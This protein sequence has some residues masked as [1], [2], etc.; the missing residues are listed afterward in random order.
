MVKKYKTNIS[1]IALGHG[2]F[3]YWRTKSF[4]QIPSFNSD[5]EL[6]LQEFKSDKI[7]S[8]SYNEI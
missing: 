3:H 1:F 8:Y 6:L 2:V 4:N 5:R 7:S